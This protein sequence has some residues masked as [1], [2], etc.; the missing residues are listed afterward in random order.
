[1][2]LKPPDHQYWTAAVG[3]VELGVFQEAND[4]VENIDPFALTFS[5]PAVSAS[6]CY[7]CDSIAKVRLNLFL[8]QGVLL[9]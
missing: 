5:R 3:Y 7:R 9:D 2:P 4:Q 6:I 8:K 1:M